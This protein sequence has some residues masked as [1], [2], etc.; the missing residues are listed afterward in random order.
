MVRSHALLT[1]SLS[2]LAYPLVIYYVA[3]YVIAIQH[4]P[5]NYP[6][7]LM[8]SGLMSINYGEVSMTMTITIMPHPIYWFALAVG[9]WRYRHT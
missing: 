1:A 9:S 7:I 4:I 5:T 3:N 8:G 6:L 2:Y